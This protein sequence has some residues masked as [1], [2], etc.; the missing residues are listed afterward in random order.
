VQQ[1][2]GRALFR[3][4]IQLVQTSR[5]ETV[6]EQAYF[7]SRS[8]VDLET[9]RPSTNVDPSAEPGERPAENSL[10]DIAGKGQRAR[11]ARR[12]GRDQSQFAR[13]EILSF[14]HYDM[15]EGPHLV[16]FDPLSQAIADFAER[17]QFVRRQL[18]LQTLEDVPQ[19]PTKDDAQS[20]TA[21]A[22]GDHLVF[23]ERFNAPIVDDGI[24]FRP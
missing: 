5:E 8:I 10:T 3:L 9:V 1:G 12:K 14:V 20:H 19:F 2:D 11:A 22:T 24:P 16:L 6:R 13:A 21:A 17:M 18:P 15:R 4:S 23:V 7:R